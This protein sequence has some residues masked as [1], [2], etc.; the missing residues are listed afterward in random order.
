MPPAEPIIDPANAEFLNKGVGILLGACDENLVPIAARAT[1]CKVS[2]DRSMVTVFISAP[3]AGKMLDC[4]RMNGAIS[5]TFSLPSTHR[6][7]QLKGNDAK[8]E[9]LQEGDI[10][11]VEAY[12]DAFVEQ[13]R[14]LGYDPVK[15]RR[16]V[17][18]P[19]DEL[20]AVSFTPTAAFT[21]TPGP[22]A[23]EPLAVKP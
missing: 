6:T 19:A 12:R 4:L 21:Q 3:Q 15:I 23:G 13:L 8:I 20:I 9:V 22:G 1:G 5:A 7:I 18:R 14:M 11:I 16:F 17:T 10:G 2:P